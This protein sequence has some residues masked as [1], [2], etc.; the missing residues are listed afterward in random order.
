MVIALWIIFIYNVLCGLAAAIMVV[1][2][3]GGNSLWNVFTL[4][5]Y[6]ITSVIL[7]HIVI[8]GGFNL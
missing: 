8:H 6:V 3:S 7:Y 1:T 5:S 4:I 2:E